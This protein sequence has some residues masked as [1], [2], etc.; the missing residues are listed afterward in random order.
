MTSQKQSNLLEHVSLSH[1]NILTNVGTHTELQ[2]S[3]SGESVNSLG[4]GCPCHCS[5]KLWGC[6][7]MENNA[8]HVSKDSQSLVMK[9]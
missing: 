9:T 7:T 8:L 4:W 3:A 5:Q 2:F 6:I 1:V